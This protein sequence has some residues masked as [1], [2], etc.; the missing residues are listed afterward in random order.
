MFFNYFIFNSGNY[1]QQE[2]G[3]FFFALCSLE[4]K[5]LEGFC[6]QVV[7]DADHS[8]ICKFDSN[9]NAMRELVLMTIT[10]EAKRALEVAWNGESWHSLAIIY[11]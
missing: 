8:A 1:G 4:I 9:D 3:N 5:G 2:V 7:I 6:Q 10:G 11:L